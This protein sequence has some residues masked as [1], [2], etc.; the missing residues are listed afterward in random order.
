MH[1][2]FKP[3]EKEYLRH[4]HRHYIAGWVNA[5]KGN[6]PLREALEEKEQTEL[7]IAGYSD[8]MANAE[9]CNSG[10]FN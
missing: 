6:P 2:V 4:K 10:V 1:L 5:K 9:A 7:Y 3:Q 8:Y